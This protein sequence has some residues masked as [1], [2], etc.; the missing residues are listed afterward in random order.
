M[1]VISAELSI[2]LSEKQIGKALIRLL[3]QKQSDLD[4]PCLSRPFYTQIKCMFS[5][6]TNYMLVRKANRE[7]PDQTAS[8]EAI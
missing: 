2:C 3:L 5:G 8:L 4:L 1:L 7:D 6:L